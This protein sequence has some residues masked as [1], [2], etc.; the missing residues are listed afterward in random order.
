MEH[1]NSHRAVFVAVVAA[2]VLPLAF[3]LISSSLRKGRNR[4][5]ML[6]QAA[7]LRLAHLQCVMSTCSSCTHK[8]GKKISDFALLRSKRRKKSEK[9][10]T[11]EI[12]LTSRF[13]GLVHWRAHTLSLYSSIL[14]LQQQ[15]FLFSSFIH[16]F[17]KYFECVCTNV[18]NRSSNSVHWMQT[19]QFCMDQRATLTQAQNVLRV[20][21]IILKRRVY[22]IFCSHYWPY[23]GE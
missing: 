2:V 13:K 1:F 16:S 23:C 6:K 3:G 9:R 10:I 22:G 19:V 4:W 8:R 14:S 12:K 7:V 18:K 11:T 21:I 15:K 20:F 5:I 17:C